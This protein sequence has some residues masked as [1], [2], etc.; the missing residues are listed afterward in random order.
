MVQTQKSVIMREETS[1]QRNVSVQHIFTAITVIDY[2]V[3]LILLLLPAQSNG[4]S[5]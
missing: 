4:C 2:I 5:I 1:N 3:M